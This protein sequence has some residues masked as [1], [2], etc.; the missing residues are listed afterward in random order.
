MASQI[1]WQVRTNLCH[2]SL[3]QLQAVFKNG[4][5][6]GR[7]KGEDMKKLIGILLVLGFAAIVGCQQSKPVDAV[8][9]I[10]NRQITGHEGFDLDTSQLEYELI[11]EDGDS[12]RVAVSGA[13][14]VNGEFSLKKEGGKW[15]LA[16]KETGAEKEMPVHKEAAPEHH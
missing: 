3:E 13:V 9:E 10:I 2:S 5:S 11:E 12:A 8:K 14:Q 6:I 7:I 4:C 16:G 15:V 1:N